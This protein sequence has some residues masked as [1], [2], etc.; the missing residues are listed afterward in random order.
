MLGLYNAYKIAK[1]NKNN[2]RFYEC[3]TILSSSLSTKQRNSTLKKF[4]MNAQSHHKKCK[5]NFKKTQDFGSHK[6]KLSPSFS[7]FFNAIEKKFK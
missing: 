1:T 6:L 5:G 3:K 7:P 4:A 2:L